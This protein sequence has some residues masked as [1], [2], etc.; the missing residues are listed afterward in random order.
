[1]RSQRF[2]QGIQQPIIEYR[3]LLRETKIRTHRVHRI[4][5]VDAEVGKTFEESRQTYSET[6]RSYTETAH[7]LAENGQ[8]HGGTG[9]TLSNDDASHERCSKN[10]KAAIIIA[11]V[12][13]LIILAVILA[14]VIVRNIGKSRFH[15]KAQKVSIKICFM[16]IIFCKCVRTY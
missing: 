16:S 8:I 3:K 15:F 12:I 7:G 11:I 2:P 4:Q 5:P 14:I 9:E 13:F 1:M 10:A 6:R